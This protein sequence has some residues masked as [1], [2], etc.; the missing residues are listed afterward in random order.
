MLD[1]LEKDLAGLRR[2]VA[3]LRKNLF[4]LRP[5]LPRVGGLIKASIERNFEEGGRYMIVGG[6]AVGGTQKWKPSKKPKDQRT[7]ESVGGKTLIGRGSLANTIHVLRGNNQLTLS[8][9]KAY[10]AIHHYG[11]TIQHPGGQPFIVLGS[12]RAQ[13]LKKD[14]E[15]PPGVRFTEPHD[16]VMPARPYMVVQEEDYEKISGIIVRYHN[17][18]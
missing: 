8:S 4:D 2:R 11:G 9:A 14:G 13:F 16:I 17:G 15:Y 6:E 18:R 12:G 7:G 5:L 1:D 3:E 10:A